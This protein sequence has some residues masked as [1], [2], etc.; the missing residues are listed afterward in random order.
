M[1][2]I[3]QNVAPP[4]A[5]QIFTIGSAIAGGVAGYVLARELAHVKTVPRDRVITATIVSS[6]F[7]LGAAVLLAR[8]LEKEA[9]GRR[10]H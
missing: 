3:G 9:I 6:V 2:M 4:I 1:K 5:Q 8:S 7:T 10:R